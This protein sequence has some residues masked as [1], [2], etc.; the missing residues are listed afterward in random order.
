MYTRGGPVR[1]GGTM[2]PYLSQRVNDLIDKGNLGEAVTLLVQFLE[3]PERTQDIN[4]QA[5]AHEALG[6]LYTR[7]NKP[8]S[9]SSHLI[10][11]DALYQRLGNPQRSSE[12][13]QQL[14]QI[15][16]QIQLQQIQLQQ[17]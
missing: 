7:M 1:G 9:A 16:L 6:D 5:A 11:A 14:G 4:G 10:N 17:R 2:P 15:Q 3:Q 8:D 13:R 12:V